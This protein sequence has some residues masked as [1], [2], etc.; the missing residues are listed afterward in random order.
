MTFDPLMLRP[1]DMA[2]AGAIVG[3][4]PRLYK[5]DLE[6]APDGS[7]YLYRWHLLMR[8]RQANVYF[9]I[10]VASDPER[11]LHDHPWDNQSV[12]LAGGYVE[13]ICTSPPWGRRERIMRGIGDVVQRRSQEA[14]RLELP[15]GVP[16]TM[17]LFT[18]G[19]TVR[20]WGFWIPTHRGRP[21]WVSHQECIVNTPD[22]KSVFREPV[23]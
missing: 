21:N 6:I 20:D 5:P 12:I 22:G 23:F 15:E 3:G 11:P 2:V 4:L 7:P 18:T 16:Y 9:H 19:P 13:H 8:N 1:A 14:H 17:T 10:Q